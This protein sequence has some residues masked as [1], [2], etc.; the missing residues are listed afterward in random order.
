MGMDK[1]LDYLKLPLD[2]H[3]H[4]G[5]DDCRNIAKI[6]RALMERKRVDITVSFFK[7]QMFSPNR[8]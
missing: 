1:M 8:W 5:I 3:H 6:C 4:S 2:G 7:K